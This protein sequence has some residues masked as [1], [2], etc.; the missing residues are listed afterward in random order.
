MPEERLVEIRRVLLD[1]AAAADGTRARRD[2][3]GT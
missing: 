1:L 2:D 3:E